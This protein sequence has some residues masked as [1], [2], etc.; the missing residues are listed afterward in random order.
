MPGNIQAYTILNSTFMGNN[1]I[2]KALQDRKLLRDKHTKKAKKRL[3]W[4]D[5]IG[6]IVMLVLLIWSTLARSN[7][8]RTV[9]FALFRSEGRFFMTGTPEYASL[10]TW[11]QTVDSCHK[12]KLFLETGLSTQWDG[13]SFPMTSV[14]LAS[15]ALNPW[16]LTQ[17]VLGITF[18]ANVIRF[19]FAEEMIGGFY[20]PIGSQIFRWI[21][22]VLTAPLILVL[23]A[24][25]SGVRDIHC[26]LLLAGGQAT[27][28]MLGFLNELLIEDAWNT[29]F[30][31]ILA[32]VL[33]IE[34][35]ITAGVADKQC[36]KSGVSQA[37]PASS[38][39]VVQKSKELNP[40]VD[41]ALV[42]ANDKELMYSNADSMAL[43]TLVLMHTILSNYSDSAVRQDA[44]S[45]CNYEYRVKRPMNTVHL[46]FTLAVAWA[47]FILLWIVVIG[48][49]TAQA[50]A[51]NHSCTPKPT[52]KSGDE[53]TTV[54]GVVYIFVWGQAVTFALFGVV[55]TWQIVKLWLR[56]NQDM[57]HEDA[58]EGAH[59]ALEQGRPGLT[60]LS[61]SYFTFYADVT[62][63]FLAATYQYSILNIIAKGLLGVCIIVISNMGQS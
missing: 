23:C 2:Q 25:A 63:N 43:P 9:E 7:A 26:L 35:T 18:G 41:D 50:D 34:D 61:R 14:A 11:T 4:L 62:A 42:C 53:L 29:L 59:G 19:F 51:F 36:T 17:I 33:Q 22:Y 31:R 27:L 58:V 20:N 44:A 55:Q 24:V 12:S 6:A 56:L 57:R 13:V 21:E 10:E 52:G 3:M 28:C 16:P 8:S 30:Y 40:E 46:M 48:N 39:S 60:A 37:I 1:A 54:P 45:M 15:N 38:K 32:G 47:G 5:A 49:F